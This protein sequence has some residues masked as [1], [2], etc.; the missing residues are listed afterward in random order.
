MQG[1][2]NVNNFLSRSVAGTLTCATGIVIKN[3]VFI[4]SLFVDRIASTKSLVYY[5]APAGSSK[6]CGSGCSN[7]DD[8][9]GTLWDDLNLVFKDVKKDYLFAKN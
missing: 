9:T 2:A 1:L 7:S 4:H 5:V 6:R 3:M 8:G